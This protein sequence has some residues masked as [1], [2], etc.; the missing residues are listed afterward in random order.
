MKRPRKFSKREQ[1]EFNQAK[2]A[3]DAKSEGIALPVYE[4]KQGHLVQIRVAMAPLPVDAD[5]IDKLIPGVLQQLKDYSGP[6]KGEVNTFLSQATT[7]NQMPKKETFLPLLGKHMQQIH[8]K[9]SND[10]EL[11]GLLHAIQSEQLLVDEKYQLGAIQK[12]FDLAAITPKYEDKP[13]SKRSRSSERFEQ[14]KEKARKL[15]AAVKGIVK[16]LRD[17]EKI[18]QGY[19]NIMQKYTNP[20]EK[21]VSAK[22]N[23]GLLTTVKINADSVYIHAIEKVLT[24]YTNSD[25]SY[26]EYMSGG[27]N[28]KEGLETYLKS[29]KENLADVAA[30]KAQ[31]NNSDDPSISNDGHFGLMIQAINEVLPDKIHS[32]DRGSYETGKQD[33]NLETVNK[34]ASEKMPEQKQEHRA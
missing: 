7:S 31:D 23:G 4:A 16:K 26:A 30:R 21:E 14:G 17:P 20:I 33:F 29:L 5:Y 22:S 27:R 25:H 2:M 34:A 24:D 18:K 15:T 1:A 6:N 10:T 32:F 11:L 3:R 12:D 9:L 13:A 8:T 19:V 28:T